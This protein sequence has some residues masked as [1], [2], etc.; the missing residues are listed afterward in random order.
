LMCNYSGLLPLMGKMD[1]LQ[2]PTSSI[3]YPVGLAIVVMISVQVI[4]AKELG[5]K[6][7]KRLISPYV[8]VFPLMLIDEFVKPMSMS[9]RLYGNTFGDEQVVEVLSELIP[10]ALPVAMQFLVILLGLIQA[11][12]FSLLA[13]IY[14]TEA[15]ELEEEHL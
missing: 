6:A 5:P 14:I 15:C 3:N 8:F 11:V 12:V 10:V 13:A 4:G 2:A 1:G 7:F 9:L